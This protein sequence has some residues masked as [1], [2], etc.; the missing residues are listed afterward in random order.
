[1]QG[2]QWPSLS[3]AQGWADSETPAQPHHSVH[4]TSMHALNQLAGQHSQDLLLLI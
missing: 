2:W 4:F 3:W 1:M